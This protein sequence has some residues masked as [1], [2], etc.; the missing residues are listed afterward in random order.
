MSSLTP[1]N[2]GDP[3]STTE[4]P[5]DPAP[6]DDDRAPFLEA[7]IVAAMA[8][9]GMVQPP[10][11]AARTQTP[12]GRVALL[13]LNFALLVACAALTALNTLYPARQGQSPPA[14]A[15]RSTVTST[16]GTSTG[17]SGGFALPSTPTA[18][19][20]PSPTRTPSGP[21][22]TPTSAVLTPTPTPTPVATANPDPTP[23]FI[24][25]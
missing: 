22:A 17:S 2:P 18:T 10:A 9:V 25:G 12:P 16:L 11:S 14:P 20:S 3:G 7:P 19:P 5:R 8:H 4:L 13:A 23:C 1:D 15:T 6:S 24:C 21:V